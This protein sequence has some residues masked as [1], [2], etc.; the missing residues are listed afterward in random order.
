MSNYWH[1]QLH[2]GHL[3]RFDD[4][5]FNKAIDAGIIGMCRGWNNDR[6]M[7]VM[8]RYDV[9][10]G[11]IIMVRHHGAKV[12]VEVISDVYENNRVQ[13]FWFDTVRNVKVL[14]RDGKLYQSQFDGDWKEGLNM[15]ASFQSAKNNKFILYWTNEVL[16]LQLKELREVNESVSI[17]KSKYSIDIKINIV[18]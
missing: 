8:F 2:P 18:P 1:I 17:V 3:E 12:L 14:S 4:E 13:D 6:G 7:P 15:N 16:K 11:D 9:A 5:Q 10:I